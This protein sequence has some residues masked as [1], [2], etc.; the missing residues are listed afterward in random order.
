L[1]RGPRVRLSAES[2]RDQALF[3]SGLLS[4]KMF[5]PS[6]NPPQPKLGLNAAFGGGIDWKTSEGEDRYRRGLYTRHG[7]APTL[8]PPWQPLTLPNREVCILKRDRSN[9][10]L[11]ALVTL[12]DPAFVET[13]QALARRMAKSAANPSGKITHGFRLC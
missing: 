12:N 9:T 13:A 5:G 6:V 11:Q 7:V 4:E 8:T 1:A 2:I 10:P 3:A